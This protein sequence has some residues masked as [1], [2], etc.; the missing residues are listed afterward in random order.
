MIDVVKKFLSKAGF[1]DCRIVVNG[2]KLRGF[3]VYK[4]NEDEIK[5]LKQ[6]QVGVKEQN[7]DDDEV[8]GPID[9]QTV[10]F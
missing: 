7:I 6:S 4:R 2:R 5:L 1:M 3:K 10:L 9:Q 8:G